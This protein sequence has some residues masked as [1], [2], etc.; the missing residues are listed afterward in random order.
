MKSSEKKL[1]DGFVGFRRGIKFG[2]LFSSWTLFGLFFASQVLINRAYRGRPLNLAYT[3]IIWL[4]CAY[5]WAALTPLVLYLSSRFRVERGRLGNL[6]IH[7]VA[8]LVFS[9]IQLGA[10][11]AVISFTDPLTQPVADVF[12][13]FIVTGLHFNL[14]TYWALVALSHAADYYRKYQERE[15]SASQLRA[16]LAHAQLSALKMQLHPHFLFNTLNAIAVLVRKSCNKEAVNMISRLSDLLRQ[17]FENIDTQE[18]S[19]K[20]ELE[21]LKSYLEIEQIRFNDRLR[22][23]MEV[24]P[25]TLAA[26][27]PN[28]ILQPLV[29]NAIRHGIAKR[30]AAG[31]LEISAR[32]ESGTLWLQV[33]DDG[34]GMEVNGSKD[35][36]AQIGLTNTRTRLQQLYGEE[37]TFEL[38]NAVGGGAIATLA[39][40]FREL[41]ANREV[42]NQ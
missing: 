23:R 17:S 16:Q 31:I 11:L 5:I 28:L 24:Q 29:E 20:E 33:R 27:V 42:E 38:A 41:G 3:L 37:Q 4:I 13:E 40:P 19:L 1:G 10:Y 34:P 2:V 8:S 6:L 15:L 26:M 36:G 35:A 25:E 32:R 39:I 18:V 7:L 12:Q 21:F 9:L 14:L 30:S 22:V